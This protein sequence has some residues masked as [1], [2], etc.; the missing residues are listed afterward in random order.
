MGGDEKQSE[1]GD[2]GVIQGG[3][4][5]EVSKDCFGITCGASCHLGWVAVGEIHWGHAYGGGEG[6]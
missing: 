1:G 4:G 5:E 6:L 3:G 2:G